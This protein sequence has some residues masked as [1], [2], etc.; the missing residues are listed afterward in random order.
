MKHVFIT[1]ISG[2]LGA[3]LVPLLLGQ[4]FIVKALLRNLKNYRELQHQNLT[5]IQGNL[6]DDLSGYLENIDIFIHIA[7]ETAQNLLNYKDYYNPNVK[8]A[9]HL[10][11]L[12]I[13]KKVKKF[14]FISSAN[15]LGFGT[16]ENLGDENQVMKFPFTESFYAQSKKE[17]EDFLLLKKDQIETL[18]LN[19]TF[20]LGEKDSK[21]SSGKII[22]MILNKK[23]VFYPSG[24]KNFVHVKDVAQGIINAINYGKNGEKY[25]LAGENLSYQ[26]FF[27][28][29]NQLSGQKTVL[30][31]LPNFL[32]IFLGFFGNFLRFFNIKTELN[33]TNMKILRINNYFS[34]QKSVQELHIK[35][36]TVDEA[37]GEALVYFKT[38]FNQ[39]FRY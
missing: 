4:G 29:F 9:V 16:L 30:I 33:S 25:L 10:Q 35:Y 17:A 8:A 19:P 26:S 15:T 18:I 23:L 7:A 39:D 21:P 31:P 3:N 12:C 6:M 27:K 14:I 24:G 2:L 37:I 13:Q 36:H 28:K 32:L 1:G 20:M 5:L 38:D 22:L 34:N 11:K